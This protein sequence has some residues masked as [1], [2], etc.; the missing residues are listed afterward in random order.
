MPNAVSDMKYEYIYMTPLFLRKKRRGLVYSV[1]SEGLSLA[2][3][4]LFYH[5]LLVLRV[6]SNPDPDN[7]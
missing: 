1:S 6:Y 3:E 2:N 4:I 5:K 7:S